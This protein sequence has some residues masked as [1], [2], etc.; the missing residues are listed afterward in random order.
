MAKKQFNWA[1]IQHF[2][3]EGNSSASTAKHFGMSSKTFT[4]AVR[5]GDLKTR[6]MS[7]AA[8]IASKSRPPHS[9]STKDKLSLIARERGFGGK[10][11]RKTFPY[12]GVCLES[13]YELKLAQELDANDIKWIRPGRFYWNDVDGRKRHYTPD[14]FLPDFDVYL[15]PKND[16]LIKIDTDKIERVCKDNGIRVLVLTK[17]QLTWTYIAGV[18]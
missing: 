10:N 12:N 5:R 13:S 14:F 18:V 4:L 1:S 8:T 17:D 7:E 16:Y 15:D 3:D 9:Q 2:Y 11:Y 6:S